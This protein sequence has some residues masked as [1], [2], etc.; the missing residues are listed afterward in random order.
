MSCVHNVSVKS[1]LVRSSLG[2][3][4]SHAVNESSARFPSSIGV[5]SLASCVQL[6]A[7]VLDGSP[8]LGVCHIIG[9]PRGGTMCLYVKA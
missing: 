6:A 1:S 9:V 8:A 4:A 7:F 3:P 2:D 5:A